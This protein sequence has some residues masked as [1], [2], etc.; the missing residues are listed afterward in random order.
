MRWLM[1][2]LDFLQQAWSREDNHGQLRVDEAR[3]RVMSYADALDWNSI[4]LSFTGDRPSNPQ[5]PK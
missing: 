2:G 4:L 1:R 5:P 3:R